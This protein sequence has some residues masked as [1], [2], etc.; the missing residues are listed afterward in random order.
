MKNKGK[1]KNNNNKKILNIDSKSYRANS[2]RNAKKYKINNVVNI[3]KFQLP[4]DNINSELK[5][6]K[7]MLQEN[8]NIKE[9]KEK[10]LIK[11]ANINIAK[12]NLIL[13]LR[14]ELNFQKLL[15]T[16]LLSYKEYADNNSNS[17]KKNYEDI[18]KYKEQLHL[19]MSDFIKLVDNYEKLKDEYAKE[20]ETI[21]QTNENLIKYKNG[22]QSKLKSTLDKLNYD[23]QNQKNTIERL[24]NTIREYK[25]KNDE[26]FTK[27]ENNEA[28]H[29]KKYEILLNEFK[30]LEN[31]YEYYFDLELKS[32]KNN[33]DRMDK[34]L[35]AEEEGLAVLRLSDKQVKSQYLKKII[36]NIQS[37]IQEIEKLN[38]RMEEDR[39]IAKL[40]GKR[41]AEKFRERMSEKYKSEISTINTKFNFTVTSL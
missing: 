5:D 19:D 12:E 37:Q 30:R 16:K 26:Y 39:E 25:E 35:C 34:N 4:K 33:L 29:D 24:G 22:E 32:R 27:I 38:K 1:L 40:L 41:G 9:K 3:K 10:I 13:S 2:S 36:N 11:N 6:I 17:Y 14:K 31:E 21:I 23:T 18:C 8:Q 7:K 15:K 28:A 20:N